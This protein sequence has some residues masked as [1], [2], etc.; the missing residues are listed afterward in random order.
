MFINESS[1]SLFLCGVERVDLGDLRDKGIL[2]FDGMIEGLMRGMN[3]VSL[4][5]ED[6]YEVSTEIRDMDLLGFVSLGELC[7]DCDL[8]DLFP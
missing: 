7:Q 2:E 3:V 5:K 8:V 4:L 1:T 6:I